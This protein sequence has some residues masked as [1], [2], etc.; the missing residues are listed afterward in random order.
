MGTR[1]MMPDGDDDGDQDPRAGR[2]HRPG[3]PGRPVRTAPTIDTG[4]VRFL[5]A[6]SAALVLPSWLKKAL[7]PWGEK[8]VPR[9]R[10]GAGGHLADQNAGRAQSVEG[11]RPERWRSRC[12]IPILAS[13]FP[14]CR[15]E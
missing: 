5:A 11:R 13:F 7:R 15:P 10:Q 9:A 4:R 8:V 1:L 3:P 14:G 6:A 2:R 12:S